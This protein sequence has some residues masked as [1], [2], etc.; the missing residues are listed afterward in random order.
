MRHPQFYELRL[1]DE[2]GMPDEDFPALENNGGISNFWNEGEPTELCLC[3]VVAG[4]GSSVSLLNNEGDAAGVDQHDS[5]DHRDNS[6]ASEQLRRLEEAVSH[7]DARIVK[8]FLPDNGQYSIVQV[9][10]HLRA[11]E[12]LATVQSK[13]RLPLFKDEYQFYV[14]EEDK[15]SFN[16]DSCLVQLDADVH[17]LGV[18]NLE[19]RKRRYADAPGYVRE[20]TTAATSHAQFGNATQHA[21]QKRERGATGGG[22]RDLRGAMRSA[23]ADG[24]S[25]WFVC[26]ACICLLAASHRAYVEQHL[27][28]CPGRCVCIC[29]CTGSTFDPRP[30]RSRT[31]ARARVFSIARD[32]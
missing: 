8:V 23:V 25:V 13:Q 5:D 30:V 14:S 32:E 16:L 2:D 4:G 9:A 24:V 7:T 26:F 11:Y 6:L 19:L 18:R 27:R 17:A 21:Q 29:V 10:P 22:E 1:H 15:E 3:E 31:L 12:L 20:D 28:C